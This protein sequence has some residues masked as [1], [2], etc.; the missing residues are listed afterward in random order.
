MKKVT[1]LIVVFVLSL[2]HA[3]IRQIDLTEAQKVADRNARSL[4]GENLDPAPPVI[5]YGPDDQVIAYHFTYAIDDKFP[6]A[7]SLKQQSSE[8][9]AIG[10]RNSGWGDDKFGNMVIGANSKLPVFVEWSQCLSPQYALAQQLD[11]FAQTL[12]PKGYDLEKTYYYGIA[13]VWYCLT[14]GTQKQYINLEPRPVAL[15][16]AEFREMTAT[17]RYFWEDDNNEEE[18]Q[19]FVD[20]EQIIGR[21]YVMIPGENYMPYYEWSYGCVPTAA[22]MVL[23]WWDNYHGLGKLIDYHLTRSDNIQG[24]YD[25]HVPSILSILAN[26]MYTGETS[27][28]TDPW[29]VNDGFELAAAHQGYIFD[30]E[31]SWGLWWDDYFFDE[32][33]DFIND[34]TPGLVTIDPGFL[35]Y[36]TVAGVGYNTSPATVYTHDSNRPSM[37]AVS[38]SILEADWYCYPELVETH[39]VKVL[40]PHGGTLWDTN[41]N[42]NEIL[43]SNDFFE[44]TWSS[45]SARDTYVKLYYHDMG[46]ATA[47]EW[48]PITDYTEDD[49]VYD[50]QV[51][52]IDCFYG[53]STDYGR[54]KIELYDSN[55]H[56]LLAQDGSYGNF[57]IF[58]GGGLFLLSSNTNP[59]NTT[60]DY[61]SAGIAQTNTWSV[62]GIKDNPDNG[63]EYWKIKLYDSPQFTNQIEES[64]QWDT[65]NYILIDNHHVTPTPYGVKFE[66]NTGDA[67]ENP[68]RAQLVSDPAA[69]LATGVV[70]SLNWGNNDVAKVWNVYLTPG[71]YFFDLNIDYVLT[72]LNLALYKWGGDGI[73]TYS[74]AVASSRSGGGGVRE[75]FHYS[76]F[77]AGYYGLVVSSRSYTG[78][79]FTLAV[80]SAGKWTGSVNTDWF[81]SGNWLGGII[82]NHEHDAII[83]NGCTNYP[84]IQNDSAIIKTLTIESN[85]NLYVNDEYLVVYGDMH[86]KGLLILNGSDSIVEAYGNVVWDNGSAIVSNG[87]SII[88]CFRNWIALEGSEAAYNN[89]T[90]EFIHIENSY[91]Q[92]DSNASSLSNVVIAKTGGATAI[93]SNLSTANLKINGTLTINSGSVLKSESGNTI[94]LTNAIQNL[95]NFQLDNGAVRFIGS[96]A[97]LDCGANDYF[98]NV[99]INASGMTTLATDLNIHGD[100]NIN[101]GGISANSRT[102]YIGGSW[103]NNMGSNG[104]VEGTSTVVFNGDG[105]SECTGEVFHTVEL[106]NPDC[107]LHF[108]SGTSIVSNYDW[109]SGVL[110]IDG[111]TLIIL[112]LVDDGIFGKIWVFSGMLDVYQGAYDH[113]DLNGELHIH[114]GTMNV[115]GGF[116]SSY[117]PYAN[118]AWLEIT[119]GVLDFTSGGININ[120]S[121][122]LLTADISGGTIRTAGN[123]TCSRIDFQPEGGVFE[124]YG[125]NNAGLSCDSQSNFPNFI[126]NKGS[127]PTG[128]IRSDAY[129]LESGNE[130][131]R[132]NIVTLTSNINIFGDLIIQSGIFDL[133]AYTVNVTNDVEVFDTLAMNYTT[134]L[135]IIGYSLYWYETATALIT[136]G[137]VRLNRNLI[138][139]ENATLQTGTGST[140]RMTGSTNTVIDNQGNPAYL[141][142]LVLDKANASV[143]NT[144]SSWPV[145]V[146]S[147]LTIN[148]STSFYVYTYT[149][150]VA[151]NVAGNTGSYLY[152]GDGG[153]LMVT[154]DFTSGGDVILDAG[155]L[156]CHD[157]FLLTV[158]GALTIA[159]G[160]CI[161]D[162]EYT[163]AMNSIVGYVLIQDG[164]FEVTNNGIQFASSANFAMTG[165]TMKVGWAFNA[166]HP[167]IFHPDGG[168]VEFTGAGFSTIE[169][170]PD[171]YFHDLVFNKPSTSYT[172]MF[173]NDITVNNDFIVNGG[174]VSLSGHTLNVGRDVV[175]NGGSLGAGNELD[176]INVGRNWT[177]NVNTNVFAQ[178]S[179]TV[180]FVSDQVGTVS[181]EEFNLVYVNKTS[182]EMYDLIISPNSTVY[183][184]GWLYLQFGCLKLS[185]NSTLD[186]NSNITIM[187]GGGLNLSSTGVLNTLNLAGHLYDQNSSLGNGIGFNAIS[188]CN[189]VLDGN[190]DQ[191]IN[192][193]SGLPFVQFFHLTVNKAGGSVKPFNGIT[194][195]GNFH[196]MN[197]EWSYGAAGL[198]KAVGHDF[199]IDAAGSFTDNT[200]LV[201]M[202]SWTDSNIKILGNASLGTLTIDKTGSYNTNLTGN[203][204]FADS[205][206]INLTSGIVNL[207]GFRFQMQ[208][209]LNLNTRM[210]LAPSSVLSLG[211]YSVF[212]INSGGRF[213]A[214]GTDT[215]PA[216][217]TS[218][219]GYYDFNANNYSYVGGSHIIFEKMN[220]SGLYFAMRSD[221]DSE[222]PLSY[223]TFRDGEAGGSLVRIGWTNNY[224]VPYAY[225]PANT[226]GGA[227][228][229]KKTTFTGG[230]TFYNASGGFAGEAFEDDTYGTV[231]WTYP[232]TPDAP[233]NIH[234]ALNGNEVLITWDEVPGVTGYNIYR[235]FDP[236]ASAGWEC[237]GWTD[238]NSYGDESIIVYPNAFYHVKAYRE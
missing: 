223:C 3:Q 156:V 190:A 171:N 59:V 93:F 91:I 187:D 217:L 167:G 123:L 151:G 111:G 105:Q 77:E 134:D 45:I 208:G 225:F 158:D 163:G 96:V 84:V 136:S 153:V 10:S 30:C 24:G 126:I 191:N 95:G 236:D 9:F 63:N 85:A 101:S 25:H 188:E 75:S 107:E 69:V 12:F 233:L 140:F 211:N 97:D 71:D 182:P 65:H 157:D 170:A 162:K 212:N 56:E 204:I 102:I 32:I 36:H 183:T 229:V 40:S 198:T 61:F 207:N 214:F 216:L 41:G 110:Y 192:N 186:A 133:N 2:L 14:D 43:Y 184:S 132:T 227:N 155:N 7:E 141:G 52:E 35:D 73:F 70:H 46:G 152:V 145:Y 33:K 29:D 15:S 169:I 20:E 116:G 90:V 149:F 109:T 11:D 50:W 139:A 72:D 219:D 164:I 37:R 67:G 44:I 38:R 57:N 215:F 49:G 16:E 54:V 19:T 154:G 172:T 34:G 176:V 104:F 231:F 150:Y 23:A 147:D 64:Y 28:N 81:T 31:G 42:D 114:G 144:G 86:I 99:D 51:P 185:E 238:S 131:T 82:P 230:I 220:A 39:K 232:P 80:T 121:S 166:N 180:N 165:G 78:T 160:S 128:E 129:D 181:R 13:S 213:L 117:W 66:N 130:T 175:I 58:D 199:I 228:N 226:W 68:S 137:E 74:D 98:C 8:A 210:N 168:S 125:S 55:T 205:T 200:G 202:D 112:D 122:Y 89:G 218:H 87:P 6:A 27:G 193:V 106:A 194:V 234:I 179:G 196:I 138:I 142:Y 177:N 135:L 224:T 83:P 221:I 222:F 113:I 1:L 26:A 94:V 119:G 5:Y 173:M 143:E 195:S 100:L 21:S 189:V 18:W 76:A 124:M 17:R 118:N 146:Q 174:T 108:D 201:I 197:G 209:T 53:T 103:Y 48:V 88:R 178:G 127:A 115:N 148:G 206:T 79:T 60:P 159:D 203:A 22:A 120:S 62:I 235:S 92:I 237:V 161:L 47:D 4:W